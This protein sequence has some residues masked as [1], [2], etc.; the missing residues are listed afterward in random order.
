M[1][2]PGR[3]F[4][5]LLDAESMQ[6]PFTLIVYQR[7]YKWASTC[8]WENHIDI[9]KI[10]HR[11]SKMKQFYMVS[12]LAILQNSS[13]FRRLNRRNNLIFSTLASGRNPLNPAI[14]LVPRA[15]SFLRSCPL[16]RAESLA[17]SFTSFFVVV[18]EQN[19]WFRTIFLLKLAVLLAL[20]REKWILLFRQNKKPLK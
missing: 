18:N 9:T 11:A 12:F 20:A 13:Y 4:S 2:I 17:A 10:N 15:G 16:T 3:S 19:R 7:R 14:W 5:I 6:K 8:Q 1:N